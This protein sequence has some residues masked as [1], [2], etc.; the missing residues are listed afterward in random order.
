[1][2]STATSVIFLFAAI[3]NIILSWIVANVAKQKGRSW[4]SFFLLSIFVSA[5]LMGIIVATISP[6]SPTNTSHSPS[7]SEK[8][9]PFCAESIKSEAIKCRYCGSD[10]G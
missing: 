6:A 1:M 8:T 3:V 5:I 7:T 4:I 9:C 10:L 2:E